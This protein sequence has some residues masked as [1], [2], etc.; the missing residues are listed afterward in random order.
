MAIKK[1]ATIPC[2]DDDLKSR[3][4]F[5]VAWKEPQWSRGLRVLMWMRG[6]QKRRRCGR[7]LLLTAAAEAVEM[8]KPNLGAPALSETPQL[9]AEQKRPGSQSEL[10]ALQE[11]TNSRPRPWP[12]SPLLPESVLGGD[13]SAGAQGV[14]AGGIPVV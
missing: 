12:R 1:T 14:R 8:T 11:H 7:T 5:A 6:E 10:R 13:L 2:L 9:A 4:F 3:L